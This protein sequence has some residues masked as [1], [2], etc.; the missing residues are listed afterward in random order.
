MKIE[1]FLCGKCKLNDVE[2]CACK[3]DK[4]ASHMGSVS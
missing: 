2:L 1:I 3:Q 4:V